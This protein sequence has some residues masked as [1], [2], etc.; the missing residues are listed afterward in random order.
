M[1]FTSRS[2]YAVR[3][4]ANL[5]ARREGVAL[6]RE[7]AADE[8]IPLK[9]LA[10]IMRDLGRAGL[11]EGMRGARGGFRL[12]K[13]PTD[14]SV[15]DIVVATEGPVSVFPCVTKDSHCPRQ[16]VCRLNDVWADTQQRMAEVLRNAK[17]DSLAGQAG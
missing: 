16:E 13:P 4:L 12:A 7:V 9:F 6:C 15:L 17:L 8:G 11:V 1:R 14:I 10:Q 2:E 5:A 3:A